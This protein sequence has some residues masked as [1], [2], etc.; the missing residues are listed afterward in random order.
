MQQTERRLSLSTRYSLA[1]AVILAGLMPASARSTVIHVPADEPT[2]QEG[3]SAAAS[4]D[5]VLVSP[6]TYSGPLNRDIDFGGVNVI[7]R[8][9]AG[10][11]VTVIECSRAGRG[12]HFHGG[13]DPTALVDGFTV[14]RGDEV[15]GG[16]VLCENSSPTLRDCLFEMNRSTETG[17]A[18]ACFAAS[19]FIAN[20]TFWG[21]TSEI[22]LHGRGGGLHCA[23]GSSPTVTGCVFFGNTSD[24][25][26]AVA[27]TGASSPSMIHCLI[28]GN[29][30]DSGGA[31]AC[32]DSSCATV[33]H[34]T[35]AGNIGVGGAGIYCGG[36]SSVGA[37]ST[38]IAFGYKGTAVECSP[39]GS[40]T[41]ACCDVYWNEYGDWC[42]CLE[43][44]NGI[45]GNICAD[46]LFCWY[47]DPLNR[48][49]LHAD[50]PCA[51]ENSPGCGG[52]GAFGV[53]C[54]PTAVVA[55]SWGALKGRFRLD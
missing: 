6:G 30:A 5:T 29:A 31:L 8:A 21:N 16:A 38:I 49:T 53:G 37:V 45:D 13:E 2:I 43:G 44:Q 20:C 50:S 42:G 27:S 9:A 34:C 17:G 1:A 28:Y 54:G 19:P 22:A 3:V 4:G 40:A 36:I 39:G 46:P 51:P 23:E 33:E 15:H 11:E 12:F 48:Y 32:L 41:L 26:G 55:T 47:A 24:A 14:I 10:P 18:M 52:I 25:G 7:L 35:M